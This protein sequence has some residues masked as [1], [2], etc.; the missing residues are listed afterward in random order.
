M[1]IGELFAMDNQTVQLTGN[2][3][4]RSLLAEV[5]AVQAKAGVIQQIRR[6]GAA[7]RVLAPAAAQRTAFEE[8]DSADP[9]AVMG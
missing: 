7:F 8:Y 6:A 9:R 2:H 3:F 4:R 1:R 5:A